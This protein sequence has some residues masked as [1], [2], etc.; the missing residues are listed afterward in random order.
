MSSKEEL[1]CIYSA[2]I[3]ADDEIPVTVSH[4][5]FLT[6]RVCHRDIPVVDLLLTSHI[7]G[8]KVDHHP[9]SGEGDRGTF[10]AK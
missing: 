1:A 6:S 2:L 4:V 8:W 7:L 3:L 9:K 10:L 5:L